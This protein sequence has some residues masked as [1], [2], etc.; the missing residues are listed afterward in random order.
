MGLVTTKNEKQSISIFCNYDKSVRSALSDCRYSIIIALNS[1]LKN[2][3]TSRHKLKNH[4]SKRHQH[5]RVTHKQLH[6][7]YSVKF[8]QLQNTVFPVGAIS[9][10]STD[11]T[12]S[13]EFL[14][15]RKTG[16]RNL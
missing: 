1:R 14:C 11:G 2:F 16:N 15:P 7:L 13:Y 3:W 9:M 4:S 6:E 12:S 10:S 8:K 5:G